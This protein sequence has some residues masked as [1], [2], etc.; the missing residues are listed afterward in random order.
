MNLLPYTSGDEESP[1]HLTKLKSR[2]EQAEFILEDLGANSFL[3]F[4]IF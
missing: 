3:A 2:C 1:M 4:S